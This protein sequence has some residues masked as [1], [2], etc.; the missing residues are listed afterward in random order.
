[1]S[2]FREAVRQATDRIWVVDPYFLLPAE[3]QHP[4]SR[5]ERIIDWLHE[6]LIASD[7]RILTKAHAEINA[8]ALQRFQ[9][10]AKRIN[11]RQTRRGTECSI[12]VC[13]RLT[14]KF[15]LIHDRFAIID[16]ELWHFGATVGGFHNHVNAAS[17]GWDA[18]SSGAIDFF[19]MAWS[20]CEGK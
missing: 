10:R 15:D 14:E 18:I 4:E 9:D 1:M 11:A 8:A 12:R 5:I 13:T 7:V 19:D 20:S 16:E 17:R 3:K 2:A 6:E